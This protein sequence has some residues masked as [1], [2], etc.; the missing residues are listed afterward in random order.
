MFAAFCIGL[1]WI[2]VKGL[3]LWWPAYVLYGFSAYSLT[4]LC[5]KL[6]G[7]VRREKVWMASHPK[8]ERLLKRYVKLF[9][10]KFRAFRK[11]IS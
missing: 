2:F 11:I 5:I 6:P 10:C 8:L 4:A 7:A 1:I 9:M 3:E